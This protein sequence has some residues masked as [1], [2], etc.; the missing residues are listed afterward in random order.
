MSDFTELAQ[1]HFGFLVKEY[2]FTCE[3]HGQGKIAYLSPTVV[4]RVGLGD[5]GE[6]GMN[7]DQNPPMYYYPFT[8][9]LKMFFPAEEAKLGECVARSKLEMEIVLM[10]L[11]GLLKHYGQPIMRGDQEIFDEMAK[12]ASSFL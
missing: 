9:Y 1:R 5:R 3:V 12:R 7:V 2:G 11:A 10:K 8:F 6:I 4:I